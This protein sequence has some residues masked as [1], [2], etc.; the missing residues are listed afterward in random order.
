MPLEIAKIVDDNEFEGE[1]LLDQL[2][3]RTKKYEIKA[4]QDKRLIFTRV[5]TYLGKVFGSFY[6]TEKNEPMILIAQALVRLRQNPHLK[7]RDDKIR[8]MGNLLDNLDENGLLKLRQ[9][10][11]EERDYTVI[12]QKLRV[13]IDTGEEKVYEI[14]RK[15][16]G[17]RKSAEE[18]KQRLI[19]YRDELKLIEQI[20]LTCKQIDSLISQPMDDEIKQEAA[21]TARQYFQDIDRK[22]LYSYYM[23]TGKGYVEDEF[24]AFLKLESLDLAEEMKDKSMVDKMI[25]LAS[26]NWYR[27]QWASRSFN[28]PDNL[29][30][31]LVSRMINRYAPW[32]PKGR[33]E[34]RQ[35]LE[36]IGISTAELEQAFIKHAT[37]KIEQNESNSIK[38]D[39][40]KDK[41][42]QLIVHI[43]DLK[44]ML[45]KRKK[46]ESGNTLLKKFLRPGIRTPVSM[47]NMEIIAEE[48]RSQVKIECLNKILFQ[49]SLDQHLSE[50][51]GGL[52][53]FISEGNIELFQQLQAFRVAHGLSNLA[54]NKERERLSAFV[55]PMD[56]IQFMSL[57]A[58]GQIT[59]TEVTSDKV[60]FTARGSTGEILDTAKRTLTSKGIT[61][62][63]AANYINKEFQNLLLNYDEPD[64]ELRCFDCNPNYE[65]ENDHHVN[66]K[67]YEWVCQLYPF[68]KMYFG[69]AVLLVSPIT[70][71]IMEGERQKEEKTIHEH[72]A[73]FLEK[74]V[75]FERYLL[76][77]IGETTKSLEVSV[78]DKN[79]LE[80]HF[81]S[82]GER[83][84]A[85]SGGVSN[86]TPILEEGIHE[87]FPKLNF[88]LQVL[89]EQLGGG[90]SSEDIP[91]DLDER[92]LTEEERAFDEKYSHLMMDSQG[93]QETP[94]TGG[95]LISKSSVRRLS[96]ALENISIFFDKL[97][98]E[99]YER[100]MPAMRRDQIVTNIRDACY[101]IRDILKN[102]D[103][104]S[105]DVANLL[106][107]TDDLLQKSRESIQRTEVIEE[108]F[109]VEDENVEVPIYEMHSILVTINSSY[110]VT[111]N[112]L[113]DLISQKHLSST[114][115]HIKRDQVEA[116]KKIV[117]NTESV[118]NTLIRNARN[119]KLES[120]KISMGLRDVM[121]INITSA[122]G[123]I[124]HLK[125]SQ[126]IIQSCQ[127]PNDLKIYLNVL[128]RDLLDRKFVLPLQNIQNSLKKSQT[129]IDDKQYA[130]WKP[131]GEEPLST[132]IFGQMEIPVISLNDSTKVLHSIIKISDQLADH[133][134]ARGHEFRDK[135][136]QQKQGLPGQTNFEIFSDRMTQK[137]SGV[138][139]QLHVFLIPDQK[140]NITF[141]PDKLEDILRIIGMGVGELLSLI[142]DFNKNKFA[143]SK[144][145]DALRK[146]APVLEGLRNCVNDYNDT[147]LKQKKTADLA[148]SQTN[149]DKT[150]ISYCHELSK[151]DDP[152]TLEYKILIIRG[153]IYLSLE[154]MVQH[155]MGLMKSDFNAE[156]RKKYQILVNELFYM[157]S[158]VKTE[159][160][161][162]PLFK[163]FKEGAQ[164][165][166]LDCGN[167]ALGEEVINLLTKG[168]EVLDWLKVSESGFEESVVSSCYRPGVD[169]ERLR[170]LAESI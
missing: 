127:H 9:G 24:I 97:K 124:N 110:M 15:I 123:E 79:R 52:R 38:V 37:G 121:S 44:N 157:M 164:R 33:T 109:N 113:M 122:F 11:S 67:Q 117:K 26:L 86:F 168:E 149:C 10:Q 5:R 6:T 108:S 119:I 51:I 46:V 116:T 30:Y 131:D 7:E 89:V 32:S 146:I 138:L 103:P 81:V 80:A 25:F 96:E 167:K 19:H 39:R 78:L 161:D 4:I 69:A 163:K 61:Y 31:F 18:E 112:G 170:K 13:V 57:I 155:V 34:I 147:Y 22:M 62:D 118:L 129:F 98:A 101:F 115:G 144:E 48:I 126:L 95:M 71:N 64:F 134:L 93:D 169:L 87:L 128:A 137:V 83:A 56:L 59:F 40:R 36:T 102:L 53:Y 111:L 91:V 23:L 50:L 47:R 139:A 75:E 159:T 145:I 135:L 1:E 140:N 158:H 85:S 151:F 148:R 107:K 3:E 141:S 142:K 104:E 92:A 54:E 43:S 114:M 130:I 82:A 2:I 100:R 49:L 68:I 42:Q 105:K 84:A 160:R 88:E 55:S 150:L 106:R 20:R 133:L 35:S 152:T 77:K 45:A 162:L 16:P 154:N 70:Y 8:Q 76:K 29:V 72:T 14:L 132:S 166:A 156:R 165:A 63:E 94:A 99:G 125:R 74:V 73:S 65:R 17:P 58:N 120:P 90:S 41:I 143:F 27:H 153:R 28:E 60:I 66:I 12:S 136:A 21:R